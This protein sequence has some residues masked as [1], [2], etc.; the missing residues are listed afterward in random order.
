MPPLELHPKRI[1]VKEVNWLGDLVMSLPALRAIRDSYPDSHLAV[2]V[3]KELGGFFDGMNW[4]NEV[5][6]YPHARGVRKV[7]SAFSIANCVR[8]RNF[9]LAVLFPN[10]FESALWMKLAR[11]P[12]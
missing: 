12:R 3:R 4:L 9:D 11:V 2:L 6:P 10:S 5:I 1:L 8:A 7:A